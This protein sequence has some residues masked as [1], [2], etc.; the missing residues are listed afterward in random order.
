MSGQGEGGASCFKAPCQLQMLQM[1]VMTM[2][3]SNG[4]TMMTKRAISKDTTTTKG[5]QNSKGGFDRSGSVIHA[6]PFCPKSNESGDSGGN[7]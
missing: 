6:T 1:T 7:S 5:Y 3:I 4:M 2:K